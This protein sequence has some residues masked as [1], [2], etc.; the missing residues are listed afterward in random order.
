MKKAFRVG[1]RLGLSLGLFATAFFDFVF[2][3]WLWGRASSLPV[4]AKWLQS[5]AI[6][7]LRI[8]H[9]RVHV[10]GTPPARGVLVSNHLSYV[11]VLVYGSTRPLV[12]LS[13]SEVKNWPVVGPL[14]R[15]GGT[16]YIRRQ[17]R[18]D[19]ARLGADMVPVV[20]S[21]VVVTLFLEGTSSDGQSVLPFRSSLLAPAQERGWP[22]TAAHIR[23]EVAEGSAADEV[24]YWRDMTFF[25]HFLNLLSKPR[26]DAFVAFDTP[27]TDKLDRK[28]LAN[29][30]HARVC[31]LKTNHA[32]IPTEV[33]S[34]AA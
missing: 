33:T 30:L 9:V 25:P 1:I 10:Q 16:L 22:A 5:W 34:K 23:Y 28:Q 20:E 21:G 4:R 12:F 31:R 11:D 8:L 7:L 14:T 24:C 3:I 13:K 17:D 26:I 19:V 27:I 32:I 18:S 29:E 6:R 15:C 2:R